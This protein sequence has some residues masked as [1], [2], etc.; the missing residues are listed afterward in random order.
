MQVVRITGN[1][2]EY[3]AWELNSLRIAG[4]EQP[5]VIPYLGYRKVYGLNGS[6]FDTDGYIG[7]WCFVNHDSLV[8]KIIGPV[9]PSNSS[10]GY[11]VL[12]LNY[13]SM[14]LLYYNSGKK[15]EASFSAVK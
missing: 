5:L 2:G 14:T 6:Y 13:N 12:S 8:E 4:I 9:I 15:I 1:N 3:R 7:T 11:K 10:Q